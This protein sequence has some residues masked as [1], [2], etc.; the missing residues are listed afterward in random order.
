MHIPIIRTIMR[1]KVRMGHRYSWVS[2]R[3]EI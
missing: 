2:Y 1:E 3:A